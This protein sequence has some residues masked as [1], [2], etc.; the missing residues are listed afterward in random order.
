MAYRYGMRYRGFS[1]GC[2]P[3]GV[4][5]RM[6]DPS[7][8]YYDILVYDRPL[9]AAEVNDYELE[10]IKEIDM[11]K[12]EAQE[13]YDKANT[14]RVTFQVNKKTDADIIEK[15]NSVEKKQTYIKSLIR[16]DIEKHRMKHRSPHPSRQMLL[17]DGT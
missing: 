17:S 2:Q 4:I 15:L 3:R 6:D 14:I 10:E 9:T 11:G 7:G 8:R 16:A 5:E 12:Y 13:R 1:P